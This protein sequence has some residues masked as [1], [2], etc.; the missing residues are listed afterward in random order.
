MG[1]C[2]G[3]GWC[4]VVHLQEDVE[5]VRMGFLHLIKENHGVSS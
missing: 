1:W 5:H 4:G 2:G 3:V